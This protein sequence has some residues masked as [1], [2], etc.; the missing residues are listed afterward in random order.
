MTT[1]WNSIIHEKSHDN[2]NPGTYAICAIFTPP[3]LHATITSHSWPRVR[4]ISAVMASCS[5][6][7]MIHHVI[8]ACFGY[9]RT[10]SKL[11]NRLHIFEESDGFLNC[12]R[13]FLSSFSNL[14]AWIPNCV[15]FEVGQ[16]WLEVRNERLWVFSQLIC[17]RKYCLVNFRYIRWE[18][19]S[20]S[21]DWLLIDLFFARHRFAFLS[22]CLCWFIRSRFRFFR[23]RLSI[24]ICLRCRFF[25]CLICFW[26]ACLRIFLRSFFWYVW[27][28]EIL[29]SHL[30]VIFMR[31]SEVA[32]KSKFAIHKIWSMSAAW[33]PVIHE[34]SHDYFNPATSAICAIFTA[35]TYRPISSHSWSRIRTVRAVMAGCSDWSL[36]QH[37]ILAGFGYPRTPC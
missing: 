24:C 37:V 13:T 3:E 25:C 17:L 21:S 23:L 10:P 20:P 36:I 18:I 29:S 4:T 14:N 30:A 35:S 32:S 22:L 16:S 2:L 1:A 12:S 15:A 33:S 5:D 11:S 28:R 6:R 8:L 31:T 19:V 26:N 7:S 9:S 34:K 27:A